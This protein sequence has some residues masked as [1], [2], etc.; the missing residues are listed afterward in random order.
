MSI[1]KFIFALICCILLFLQGTF[2]AGWQQLSTM[3]KCGP[4]TA[5]IYK[6][7]IP[8]GIPVK[9]IG[10]YQRADYGQ[11]K[12]AVPITLVASALSSLMISH[13]SQHIV[14]CGAL[15]YLLT[16]RKPNIDAKPGAGLAA[17]RSAFSSY[18]VV[19]NLYELVA[20]N[21]IDCILASH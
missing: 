21:S 15:V 18:Q 12:V 8:T 9:R 13:L 4:R 17:S 16:S 7:S 10:R 11:H 3:Q 14:Q 19:R 1:Y 20:P 2:G 6:C 5:S